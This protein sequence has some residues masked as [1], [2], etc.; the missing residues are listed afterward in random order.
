M[1]VDPE[2]VVIH[3]DHVDK[4]E[5]EQ[6]EEESTYPAGELEEL[7]GHGVVVLVLHHHLGKGKV[8]DEFEGELA[9]VGPAIPQRRRRLPKTGR[10]MLRMM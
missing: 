4:V 1:P 10:T 2:E 5:G 8:D 9:G 6:P 7:Q 3:V